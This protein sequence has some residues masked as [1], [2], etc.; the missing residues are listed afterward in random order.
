V[1]PSC[2]DRP[3]SGSM[4][5]AN[6]VTVYSF[7]NPN[8]GFGS[9][10]SYCVALGRIGIFLSDH[11]ERGNHILAAE[12]AQDTH[13]VDPD[14]CI[15]IVKCVQN[16]PSHPLYRGSVELTSLFRRRLH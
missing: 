2:S 8:N 10:F 1:E 5:T 4:H 15:R 14:A 11:L 6:S 16:D 7:L 13:G 9:L 12:S 3:S